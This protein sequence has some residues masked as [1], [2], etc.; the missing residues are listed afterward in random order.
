[1]I[2]SVPAT[3]DFACYFM[4]VRKLVTHVGRT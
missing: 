1:M 3:H 2:I 4:W